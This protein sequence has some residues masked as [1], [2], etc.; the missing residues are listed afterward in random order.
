MSC[1]ARVLGTRCRTAVVTG[2]A[3]AQLSCQAQGCFSHHELNSFLDGAPFC[4][5]GQPGVP[6]PRWLCPLL[7]YQA[8]PTHV[9]MMS[10]FQIL[11]PQVMLG[12]SQSPQA[13]R[14]Q[15]P[16]AQGSRHPLLVEIGATICVDDSSPAALSLALGRRR[17]RTKADR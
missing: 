9:E 14:G 12:S 5:G 10:I 17:G 4:R 6:G 3:D 2:P 11:L 13:S 16:W 7:P 8:A 1:H 15:T